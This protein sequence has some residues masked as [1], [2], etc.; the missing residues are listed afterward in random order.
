MP[1]VYDKVSMAKNEIPWD[2]SRYQPDV[3]TVC[4]GQNDGV[5]DSTLFCA[6]YVDFALRLRTYY[7]KAK[8]VF[9]SSPMADKTLKAA[10]MKYINAV[11]AEL[12]RRGERNT[13]AYFF[14]KQSVSGCSSH[15]SQTEQKEIAG[16]LTAYLKQVMQ[17]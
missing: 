8:L 15:P 4:L 17:W 13:G 7:P 16:E 14:T 5:Q 2:F 12:L 10:L 6:A 3:V 11:Q 1:Q 9:L